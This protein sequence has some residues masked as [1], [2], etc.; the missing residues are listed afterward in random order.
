[1]LPTMTWKEKLTI[2]NK[3]YFIKFTIIIIILIIIISI[4]III[5]IIIIVI[6]YF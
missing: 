3:H 5:I 6:G 2:L 1:M 4:I